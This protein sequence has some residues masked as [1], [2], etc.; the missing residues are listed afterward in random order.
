MLTVDLTTTN[1]RKEQKVPYTR[2][3]LKG[4]FTLAD[5]M[6]KLLGGGKV[7]E[8]PT[9]V[10]HYLETSLDYLRMA[11]ANM[12][13]EAGVYGREERERVQQFLPGFDI[14]SQESQ[15]QEDLTNKQ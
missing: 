15:T 14:E 8:L 2:K 6:E 7:D 11:I 5:G 1:F 3:K 4:M 10:E 12:E 9:V 13:I